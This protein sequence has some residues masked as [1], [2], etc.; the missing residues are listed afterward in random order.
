MEFF[1]CLYTWQCFYKVKMK[2]EE[3]PESMLKE[4]CEQWPHM[5]V[6]PDA[7]YEKIMEQYECNH[8]HGVAGDWVEEIRYFCELE[9]IEFRYVQ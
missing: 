9:G 7:P 2:R 5:Y 3:M 4:T 6:E 8:I 1:I